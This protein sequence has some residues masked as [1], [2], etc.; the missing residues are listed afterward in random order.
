[1]Q[2]DLI[3]QEVDF[4]IIPS[5]YVM[6]SDD[7]IQVWIIPAFSNIS[8]EELQNI[9]AKSEFCSVI[10][11]DENQAV[12]KFV[13]A[14]DRNRKLMTFLSKKVILAKILGVA[15][16]DLNFKTDSFGKSSLPEFRNFHFNISH[17]EAYIIL[18]LG[19]VPLGIDLEYLK[20]SF[21]FRD[22]LSSTFQSSEIRNIL[23]DKKPVEKF[24]E[25]W[26]RKEAFVKAVGLGLSIPPI[27][28]KVDNVSNSI[29]LEE[30]KIEMNAWVCSSGR[31]IPSYLCS[32]VYPKST[33]MKIS[34]HHFKE[35]Y[36]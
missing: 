12:Q 14:C 1:M 26:T 28:I 9:I 10:S 32:L 16:S 27:K 25:L 3:C 15:P 30:E 5:K 34:I 11:R 8:N 4:E 13:R 35:I 19:K 2:I 33:R 20:D 6:P 17:S 18:A 31:V 7:E 22:L 24:F 29:F 21:A 23:E 36:E